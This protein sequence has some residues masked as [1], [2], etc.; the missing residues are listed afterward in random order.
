MK[1]FS[2]KQIREADAYTIRH[3]PVA[4]IDLMERASKA[5][6]KSFVNRYSA[7]TIVWIFCGTG[8]NGGDGLAIGRLLHEKNY[9]VKILV[10]RMSEKSSADFATNEK[11][12]PNKVAMST[13]GSIDQLPDIPEGIV[14]IDAIFGSGLDRPV[15]GL[16]ATVINNIN[17]SGASV[18]SVDIASGLFADQPGSDGAIIQPQLTISFQLPKMAF[19]LPENHLWVGDWEVVDIGLSQVFI[20]ETDCPDIFLRPAGIIAML[21]TRD[22]FAHKGVFGRALLVAGSTGKIG[23]AILSS[24]ACLRSGAGLLTVHVPGCGY[25]IMQIA[26]PEAMVSIDK[27]DRFVSYLPENLNYDVAGIGP[28]ID[29]REETVHLL[30]ELLSRYR[31][32]M[33]I[34]A[35]AL[36]IISQ[37]KHL[38]A[39][40]PGQSILTPHP[41][42]FERIAGT[43]DN[44][45]QRLD[46][47]R[48]FS[49]NYGVFVVFKGAYTTITTPDGQAFFN[50]TGNPGMATAGSGDVLTGIITSLLGQAYTPVE[51]AVIGVYLHGLAGDLGAREQGEEALIAGDI[52]A[53]IARAFRQLKSVNP[54]KA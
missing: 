29:T 40:I 5:F 39:K 36:N 35:D 53:F 45:Y 3:E 34:D 10:V 49:V 38:K 54:D 18:V 17:R 26:V 13:V 19:L 1:I 31:Q 42:E 16:F 9:E 47:Q 37:H 24:R 12:T 30:E 2:S 41:K 22:K 20:D 14:V 32:P 23:A 7:D 50:S 46:L 25:E 15:T 21:K 6:V 8:N 51:A 33:V 48:N 44:D 52:I 28:G 4:S 11:R 27:A 43:W